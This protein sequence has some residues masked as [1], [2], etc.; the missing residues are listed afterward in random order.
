MG[1]KHKLVFISMILITILCIS[2]VSVV[3][4]SSLDHNLTDDSLSQGMNLD[5]Y[6]ESLNFNDNQ[7]ESLNEP[8]EINE[9]SEIERQ[10]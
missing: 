2:S 8:V 6:S 10:D 9:Y 7:M 1:L 3:S 5:K 4:A